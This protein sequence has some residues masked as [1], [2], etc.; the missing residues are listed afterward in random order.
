MKPPPPSETPPKTSETPPPRWS[1]LLRIHFFNFFLLHRPVTSFL[2]GATLPKKNPGSAPDLQWC[3]NLIPYWNYSS[4]FCWLS[5]PLL[6]FCRSC[7]NCSYSWGVIAF[8]HGSR[9]MDQ[10]RLTVLVYMR[11]YLVV[12]WVME[13]YTPAAES[14]S[15]NLDLPYMC[16]VLLARRIWWL[17]KTV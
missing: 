3:D 17:I 10:S 4:V 5:L 9:V 16:L 13:R 7:G 11:I 12:W 8:S 14:Y 2:I 6:Q 1:R 15:Q